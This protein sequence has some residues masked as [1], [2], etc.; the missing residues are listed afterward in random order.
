M[1]RWIATGW[2][3]AAT[4]AAVLACGCAGHHRSAEGRQVVDAQRVRGDLG[5]KAP[6]AIV[7]WIRTDP[8]I[9]KMSDEEF[10]RLLDRQRMVLSAT[11]LTPGE[12]EALFAG[13]REMRKERIAGAGGAEPSVQKPGG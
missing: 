6:E 9:L 8:A 4:A 2:V 5:V 12:V 11:N 13:L 7:A 1:R 10:E 3:G